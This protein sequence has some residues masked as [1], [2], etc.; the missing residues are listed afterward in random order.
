MIEIRIPKMGE[1]ITEATITKWLK[2]V[3]DKISEDEPFVEIAT[4]KV[5]TDIPSP[6]EGILKKQLYKE[7]DTVAVDEVFAIIESEAAS[8][9]DTAIAEDSEKPD[10]EATES[11][12]PNEDKPQPDKAEASSQPKPDSEPEIIHSL[13]KHGRF[14]SPLV[15]SIAREEKIKMDELE[16]IP[17][18]GKDN[19]ITKDDLLNYIEKKKEGKVQE[20]VKT[21]KTQAIK[22]DKPVSHAISAGKDDEVIE[23][24][25]MRKLIAAHMVDSRDTSVHISLFAEADVTNIVNWRE[26]QKAVL[27]KR[28]GE[29]LTYTPIFVEAIANAI[30]EF[31]MVNVSVDGEKIIK[32]G[33]INIGMAAA[34]PDGNLIVPVIKNADHKSLLGLTKEVND[35]ANRAKNNQLKPD[36]IQEGTF[37]ITNIGTF[38]TIM[39]TPIIYQPQV[40]IIGVGVIRKKPVVIETEQGDTIGIRHM[41]YLSLACDHRVVDGALGGMFLKKVVDNLENFD[42]SQTI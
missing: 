24:D 34:L 31:P 6:I 18:T 33:N 1:A 26:K 40:A 19:R 36:D 4:D 5:D 11:E 2:N 28:S 42:T 23:M 3:G 22:T 16:T 13:D 41:M 30:K 25:R 15:R 37:T 20:T 21:E 8:D 38:G 27:Q 35:L 12:P 32:R 29:K 14:Y 39:G 17:G 9:N 10:K 7:G